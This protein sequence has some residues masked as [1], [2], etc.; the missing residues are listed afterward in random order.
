MVVLLPATFATRFVY[1]ESENQASRGLNVPPP[2]QSRRNEV[3][4]NYG[5]LP[6][7]FE[8]NEGQTDRQVRFLSRGPGY[9]LFLTATGAVLTLRKRQSSLLNEFEAPPLANYVSS[10]SAQETSVLRLK[11]IG[12]NRISHLEGEDELPGRVN[13]LIGDRPE[14]WQTNIPAFAKVRYE[15]IYPGVD[16]VFYGNQDQLEYDFVVDPGA[17]PTR[18]RLAFEG[19]RKIS[20]D[21]DGD[22]VL[23]TPAGDIRQRRPV[24]YQE[25]NGER[26][27]VSVRYRLKGNEVGFALGAYDPT[28]RLI[29][30]PVLIYSTFLGGTSSEQGLGIAVDLQGSAYITGSSLSTD[31]PVANAYQNVKSDFEDAFVVKLNPSG[32]GLVYSTYLGGTAATLGTQSQWTGKAVRMSLVSRVPVV[33]LRRWVPCRRRRMT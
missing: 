14:N 20:V 7:S 3:A 19:A 6:L 29:I 27:P 12:A 15:N 30:D 17:L 26:R 22:L 28:R 4:R 33:S 11:M 13:Y 2:N 16:L 23:K 31:F 32:T 9:G 5:K 25:V 10:A 21:R 1:S 8:V 24:A 18:I